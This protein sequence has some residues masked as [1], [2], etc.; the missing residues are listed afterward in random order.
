MKTLPVKK[1]GRL[2]KIFKAR[3][4][5]N[6]YLLIQGMWRGECEMLSYDGDNELVFVAAVEGHLH[7]NSV[8]PIRIFY[9]KDCYEQKDNTT[10]V[11]TPPK[12]DV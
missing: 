11:S 8:K 6:W 5:C 2:W 7:D 10:R 9:I 4:K 3:L 12:G 1:L